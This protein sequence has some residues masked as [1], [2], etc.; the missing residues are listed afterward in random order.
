MIVPSGL[1]PTDRVTV[2]RLSSR[3]SSLRPLRVSHSRTVWSNDA[4]AR[5]LP[6]G[7]KLTVVTQPTFVAER[8]DDYL[9]DV[10]P[11]DRPHLWP[12]AGL[13]R[14]GI[15]VG[16]STDAPFGPADPWQAIAAAVER[17]TAA[18]R[19]LGPDERLE[20]RRALDL[21]LGPA[22]APG[23][24]PRRVVPGAPADLCLLAVPLDEALRAPSASLVAAT[25]R[26]G[27]LRTRAPGP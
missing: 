1:K 25:V 6:S 10:E 4:V 7:L 9:A 26:A 16:G 23:G 27:R 17:R 24:P 19:I 11:D 20:A 2:S 21:F 8:G 13:L 18:G 15:A 14:A 12:C 3:T 5:R 22:A